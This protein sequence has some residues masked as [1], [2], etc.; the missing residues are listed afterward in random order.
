MQTGALISKLTR[1]TINRE[2]EEIYALL[3][4]LFLTK[5]RP[6]SRAIYWTRVSHPRNR[7]Q[8]WLTSLF[9]GENLSAYFQ[10]RPLCRV[11]FKWRRGFLVQSA[12]LQLIDRKRRH[13]AGVGEL[14]SVLTSVAEFPMFFFFLWGSIWKDWFSSRGKPYVV[15]LKFHICK[16][17]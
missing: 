1:I 6:R 14:P 16:F 11:G 4:L 3:R 5:S 13:L 15:E 12:G 7:T 9:V 10:G 17:R 2:I 8:R